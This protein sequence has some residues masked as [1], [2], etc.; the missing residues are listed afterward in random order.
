M[1]FENDD[2]AVVSIQINFI[3]TDFSV[4]FQQLNDV[5]KNSKK[6][7]KIVESFYFILM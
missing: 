1:R 7:Q 3:S 2:F 5:Q 4:R 6:Y